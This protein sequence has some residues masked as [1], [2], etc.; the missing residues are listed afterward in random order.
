MSD[1]PAPDEYEQ[2]LPTACSSTAALSSSASLEEDIALDV[3]SCLVNPFG[4]QILPT[5]HDPFNQKLKRVALDYFPLALSYKVCDWSGSKLAYDQVMSDSEATPLVGQRPAKESKTRGVLVV[6]AR[7]ATVAAVVALSVAA[8]DLRPS[9]SGMGGT[10]ALEEE[11]TMSIKVL[12]EYTRNADRKP[13]HGYSTFDLTEIVEPFRDTTLELH[14]KGTVQIASRWEIRQT[15]NLRSYGGIPQHESIAG[16]SEYAIAVFERI[17]NYDV[18]AE[19]LSVDGTFISYV[20][21][22]VACR[23]VR[24]N[25][26]T[27]D[28]TD[29]NKFLDAFVVLQ[30]VGHKHGIEKFGQD[31]LPLEHFVKVHLNKAAE[32]SHDMFH[33]GLGFTTQHAALTNRFEMSLQSI[34]PSVRIQPCSLP[35]A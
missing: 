14:H 28:S 34:D 27:M 18:S 13:G 24:R 35:C 19:I 32:R 22:S 11:E 31:Y 10:T 4:S 29:R 3:L 7:L 25:L 20:N 2:P 15:T 6:A 23:Y 30:N 16:G 5:N 21:K 9:A 1:A 26:R 33:D 12:N 17:G 8:L